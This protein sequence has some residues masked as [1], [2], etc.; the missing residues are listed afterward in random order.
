MTRMLMAKCDRIVAAHE[1][2]YSELH[3]PICGHAVLEELSGSS[4]KAPDL[5]RYRIA[6]Q[7]PDARN[8]AFQ[9]DI[10]RDLVYALV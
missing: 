7:Q 2:G 10:V 9:S 4:I 8:Q 1:G 5:I 6:V 3:V